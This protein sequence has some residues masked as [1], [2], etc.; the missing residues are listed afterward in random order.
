M[1]DDTYQYNLNRISEYPPVSDI[2][3]TL[4]EQ[5]RNPHRFINWNLYVQPIFQDLM[6]QNLY[7]SNLLPP[8]TLIILIIL[9][10]LRVG[11]LR[12][13]RCIYFLRI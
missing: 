10:I 8:P 9:I 13:F 5:R 7:Y 1:L 12:R 3:V 2:Y 6:I 11:R 4:K